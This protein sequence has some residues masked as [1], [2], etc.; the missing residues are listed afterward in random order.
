MLNLGTKQISSDRD[1]IVH[2]AV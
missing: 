1:H 2:N